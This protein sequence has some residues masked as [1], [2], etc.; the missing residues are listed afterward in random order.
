MLTKCGKLKGLILLP[1]FFSMYKQ[2]E[3]VQYRSLSGPVCVS[4]EAQ[5]DY[6]RVWHHAVSHCDQ[7]S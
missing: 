5:C 2:L 1:P 6:N 3:P 4:V 7:I